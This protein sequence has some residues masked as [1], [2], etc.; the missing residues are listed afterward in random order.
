MF[1]LVVIINI[2]VIQQK[3]LPTTLIGYSCMTNGKLQRRYNQNLGILASKQVKGT[4][5]RLGFW[6]HCP[7]SYPQTPYFTCFAIFENAIDR[8]WFNFLLIYKSWP[9]KKK[10]PKNKQNKNNPPK[11]PLPEKPNRESSKCVWEGNGGLE[12][13]LYLKN[14][15]TLW[16]ILP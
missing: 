14:L 13:H 1:T 2:T 8:V 11:D 4:W 3:I 5:T 12:F 9:K 15:T 16:W 7:I 6:I 10:H